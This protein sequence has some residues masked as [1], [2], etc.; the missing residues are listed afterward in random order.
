MFSLSSAFCSL[1][2]CRTTNYALK[3]SS[4]HKPTPG[5]GLSQ[6]YRSVTLFIQS[7]MIAVYHW[8]NVLKPSSDRD[9]VMK[10]D[11]LMRARTSGRDDVIK[12]GLL[13]R[14]Q[15]SSRDD[16]MKRGPLARKKRLLM[17][18]LRGLSA[19]LPEQDSV[20]IPAAVEV[21]SLTNLSS[22]SGVAKPS[23]LSSERI[24]R[25]LGKPQSSDVNKAA[26]SPQRNGCS[27]PNIGKTSIKFNSSIRKSDDVI[28]D[29]SHDVIS[30]SSSSAS[31]ASSA[32]TNSTVASIESFS[33]KSSAADS[34]SSSRGGI[35]SRSRKGKMMV[36]TARKEIGQSSD[37]LFLGFKPSVIKEMKVGRYSAGSRG[38]LGRSLIK[39]LNLQNS[40]VSVF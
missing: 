21:Q 28:T 18:Q 37:K 16:M 35:A 27:L 34:S 26:A 25:Y 22:C 30:R 32:S 39:A 8:D 24:L 9:D 13:A 3:T 20:P 36:E 15:S 40:A 38:G 31:I 5:R 19:S 14:A 33:S 4:T 17:D 10:P 7:R 12:R 11:L 2:D 6:R 29:Q 23:K 1:K